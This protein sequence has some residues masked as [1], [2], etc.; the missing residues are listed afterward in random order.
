MTTTARAFLLT[1]SAD[2]ALADAAGI[3]QLDVVLVQPASELPAAIDAHASARAV[4]VSTDDPALLRAIVEHAGA[5]RI[6]VVLAGENDVA[7][8]RAIEFRVDD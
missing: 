3:L 8:R 4:V 6:P 1:D 5:R 7:Y 2:A